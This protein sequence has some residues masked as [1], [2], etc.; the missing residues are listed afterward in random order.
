[1]CMHESKPP[2]PIHSYSYSFEVRELDTPVVANDYILHMTAAIDQGPDLSTGLVRQLGKLSGEFRRHY[3][4][5]R[6]ASGIELGNPPKL[7]L[8]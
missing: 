2:E 8:L 3:L 4:V 6:D 7:V 1:M 5:W